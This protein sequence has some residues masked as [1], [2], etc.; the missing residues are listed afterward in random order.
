MRNVTKLLTLLLALFL[1]AGIIVSCDQGL[2]IDSMMKL[3]KEDTS[4]SDVGK[5]IVYYQ[6]DSK[7]IS[8]LP[9]EEYIVP[10]KEVTEETFR[11]IE[12][13]FS[14]KTIFGLFFEK[15]R[16]ISG[17][18]SHADNTSLT[19]LQFDGELESIGEESFRTSYNLENV[20][21]V[22]DTL[23]QIADTAFPERNEYTT[24]CGFGVPYQYKD[25]E[26][27]KIFTGDVGYLKIRVKINLDTNATLYKTK[28]ED[29]GSPSI[30]ESEIS[31]YIG[32]IVSADVPM[33]NG[34]TF[35]GFYA[36][37]ETTATQVFDEEGEIIASVNGFT[38][39][40][41]GWIAEAEET[42][43]YAHWEKIEGFAY[44]AE[45]R[46]VITEMT[47]G[48]I[49]LPELNDSVGEFDDN[50]IESWSY[51]EGIDLLLKTGL[52]DDIITTLTSYLTRTLGDADIYTEDNGEGNSSLR[53]ED[54]I[55]GKG[56]EMYMCDIIALYKKGDNRQ[57][58]LIIYYEPYEITYYMKARAK[59]NEWTFGN[60]N[61]PELDHSVSMNDYNNI[62]DEWEEGWYADLFM[63]DL[64]QDDVSTLVSYTN[65][66]LGEPLESEQLENGELI[67]RWPFRV[68]TTEG[69]FC[70]CSIM[71][72]YKE[73]S[74]YFSLTI[75]FYRYYGKAA[76]VISDWTFEGIKLPLELDETV[77]LEDKS[78]IASWK[79]D[80]TSGANLYLTSGLTEDNVDSLVDALL[81]ALGDPTEANDTDGHYK[82]WRMVTFV[83][84]DTY[85]AGDF[86]IILSYE[87]EDFFNL[88]IRIRSYYPLD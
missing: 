1:F 39:E 5:I 88:A 37:K 80:Y 75:E 25:N 38:N 46:K 79:K 74:P 7:G 16:K 78:N 31:T 68:F 44:Y 35:L 30:S 3:K 21:F 49:E 71:M 45:A 40:K 76:Q 13:K 47:F 63:E 53:W 54:R 6:D 82:Y 65:S 18:F 73:D 8:G 42:T 20:D 85:T 43:L 87:Y 59:L 60:I 33:N 50:W 29:F 48:A 32:R 66:A 34:F 9:S 27:L 84:N 55:F 83:D 22:G 67:K 2:T 56:D 36:E 24:N 61:L 69:N 12:E 77:G 64:T 70:N 58:E 23:P 41:G 86:E 19:D 57:F 11:D 10:S 62:E 72:T 15:I 14:G 51:D 81:V 26:T 52:T 17:H 28:Y 4:G